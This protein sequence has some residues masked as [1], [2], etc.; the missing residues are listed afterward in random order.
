[1]ML[2]RLVKKFSK[3]AI[4]IFT[5]QKICSLNYTLFNERLLQKQSN[6]ITIFIFSKFTLHFKV[7]RIK[8][9]IIP[10]V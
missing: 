4:K 3:L 10:C 1:M 6:Q 8:I 9:K 7:I 2:I 5:S